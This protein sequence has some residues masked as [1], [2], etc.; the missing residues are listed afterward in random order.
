MVPLGIAI[1]LL[2]LTVQVVEFFRHRRSSLATYGWVGLMGL[3]MAE[4]LMFRG[5]ALA[6]FVLNW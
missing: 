3:A 5:F 4:L 1:T 2:S 6:Q